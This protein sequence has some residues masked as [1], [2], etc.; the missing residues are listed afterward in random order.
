[1]QTCR[2]RFGK[3]YVVNGVDPSQAS[4]LTNEADEVV[5]VEQPEHMKVSYNVPEGSTNVL[6]WNT[7]LPERTLKLAMTGL[8]Q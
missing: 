6:H 8:N 3:I 1:M 7:T 5:D 4:F 2:G